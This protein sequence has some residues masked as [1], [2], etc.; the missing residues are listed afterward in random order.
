MVLPRLPL[1]STAV[2]SA[3]KATFLAARV[4]LPGVSPRLTLAAQV[5]TLLRVSENN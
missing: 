4:P 3:Y 1:S 5:F 2:P